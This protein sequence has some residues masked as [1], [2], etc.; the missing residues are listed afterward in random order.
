MLL[1]FASP[2]PHA[3]PL[4]VTRK[5]DSQLLCESARKNPHPAILKGSIYASTPQPAL[6]PTRRLP[7]TTECRILSL[8]PPG[9]RRSS[10]QPCKAA[11]CVGNPGRIASSATLSQYLKIQAAPA[12]CWLWRL[13]SPAR[14]GNHLLPVRF[15]NSSSCF[16][17]LQRHAVPAL[18]R[19]G[20]GGAAGFAFPPPTSQPSTPR[21]ENGQ[22]APRP[23]ALPNPA[24]EPTCAGLLH[25]APRR[26][27]VPALP[28]ALPAPGSPHYVSAPPRAPQPARKPPALPSSP[29]FGCFMVH[30]CG[31]R[32][33]KPLPTPLSCTQL[34]FVLIPI[35]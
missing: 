12:P 14:R 6:R 32:R 8:R 27:L 13:L 3:L 10:E 20:G 4:A 2:K 1:C 21:G 30:G 23:P 33:A 31:G 25:A 18:R 11:E 28:L 35:R 5:G 26:S 19:W 24:G 17:R 9:S 34:R 16:C 7:S 15:A 29:G 22:E